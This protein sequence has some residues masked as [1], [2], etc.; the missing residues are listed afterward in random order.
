MNPVY[1]VIIPVYNAEKFLEKS[2]DTILAQTTASRYE[3]IL[4]NDGS[5]DGSAAI[6]DRY[7]ADDERFHVIHQ[8][9]QGVSAARNAGLAAAKGQYVLFLDSDDL[10]DEKL[11][12]SVDARITDKPDIIEFGC[13]HY[14]DSKILAHYIPTVVAKGESG[15]EHFRN[16]EKAGSLP[17][18]T[19]WGSAYRRD[20]LLENEL[21][22]P[23]GIRYG[24][25]FWFCMHC[26]KQAKSVQTIPA[27]LY[28]YWINEQ[29]ASHTPNVNKIRDL[30]STSA[31]LY[32]ILPGSLLADYYCMRIWRIEGLKRE[33][34]LQLEDLLRENSDILKQVKSWQAR[35]ARSLYGIFGWYNGAKML[36][37]L[38]DLRNLRK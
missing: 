37:K 13:L 9:N 34:V 20:F 6:C 35:L 36:R 31:Q 3:V 28:K 2:V 8:P 15:M 33:D 4:V 24:E 18:V 30:L 5:R 14:T 21:K 10:W 32:R 12:E 22:F 38:S 17:I 7:A 26:L 25:D 19:C 16:H 29:S 11:L 1:S 23:L 27:V